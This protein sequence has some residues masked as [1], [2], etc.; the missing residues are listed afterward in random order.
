MPRSVLPHNAK[1]SGST[2]QLSVKNILPIEHDIG[3]V[4]FIASNLSLHASSVI[5]W[6]G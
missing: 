3:I 5:R 1:G 4:Q 2:D 6:L